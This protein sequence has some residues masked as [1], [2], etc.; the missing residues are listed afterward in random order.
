MPKEFDIYL[1]NRLTQCDIIVY[2]IPFRDGLTAANRIILESCLESYLL[3]KFVAAQTNSALVSHIDK[4]IKICIERLQW[5]S[6]LNASAQFQT[7]YVLNPI[8]HITEISS[9]KNLE[10]LRNMFASASNAVQLT[11]D[12]VNA[13]VAK[14]LGGGKSMFA[15]DIKVKDVLKQS[16]LTTTNEMQ[17]ASTVKGMQ[18]H[19]TTDAKAGIMPIAE[20]TNLC[21]R[22]Y[23]AAETTMQFAAN[24]LGTEIHFSFGNA[25][26]DI[27]LDSTVS[28]TNAEKY[29][30]VHDV[31]SLTVR[32]IEGLIQYLHTENAKTQ[33]AF[34]AEEILKR[35]RLLSEM[36]DNT[37]ASYDDM[38]LNETDYI[39]L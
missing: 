25:N 32:T 6:A 4:M 14:S 18:V 23:S 27:V 39:I 19:K 24:V 17:I 3:Q 13:M 1:N 15:A 30:A 8:P 22:F 5:G 34:N 26:S 29:E 12:T 35:H 28:R 37:L 9:G 11:V 20:I 7:H 16:L 33:I 21:Y 2:S 36:D 31:L 38:T 10:T